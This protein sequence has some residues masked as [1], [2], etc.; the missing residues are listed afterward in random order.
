MMDF[1]LAPHQLRLVNS[2]LSTRIFLA[3][4]AGTG[5]TTA[6][7]ARLIHYLQQGIPAETLLL[8]TPQRTLASPYISAL[9]R[10]RDH[11]GGQV[12][13]LTI[14]G[15]AR[16]MIQLFW[17]IV[18]GNA[19]FRHPDHPPTFLTLETVQ[20]HIA[21]LVRPLLDQGYFSSVTI[22]RNRLYSQ[23][24][25]NL[26]KAAVV[27]FSH[28]EI[29]E[30]LKAAWAGEPG[31]LRVYDDAQYCAI[32]FRDYCIERN[33]LDFSLQIET[34]IKFIWPNELCR[35]YLI[36]TYRHLWVDNVEEDT[37][38]AHEIITEWLPECA[39]A[40]LVYD[41][42]AGYRKFLGASPD[43]G[44]QL[45]QICEEQI[46]FTE[47]FVMSQ[48][49]H[50]LAGILGAKIRKREE[51][52]PRK[53]SIGDNPLRFEVNRFFPSMLDWVCNQTSHL[54]FDMHVPPGEICILSPFLS[55][56][57]RFSLLTRLQKIGIPVKSH[58]P[59][60]ALRDEPATLCV[61]TLALLAHPEWVNGNNELLPNPFD[62]AHAL[63]QAIEGLDLIRAQLLTATLI[64]FAEAN[65]A[66]DIASF[67]QLL[68][69]MKERISYQIG[70]K[71]EYLRSWILYY[72]KSEP[73]EFDYFVSRLFGEVLSQPGFGFH[74]NFHSSEIVANLV[75]S[76]QKFRWVAESSFEGLPKPLGLE[77]VEMVREGIIAAQYLRSWETWLQEE[78]LIAPA[79]TFLMYNKAVDFQFWL[80]VGS[81][82]WSER[83]YQPLTQPYVL[84][85]S[86]DE[87][88]IWTDYD[89]VETSQESLYRLVSGLLH[90]CRHGIFL[91]LSDLG[92]QGYEQRG[93]LLSAFQKTLQ[94][95]YEP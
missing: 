25:D 5:K 66:P 10:I 19:G 12:T 24:I 45:R 59:S 76:I 77:Y 64:R 81:R 32:L 56:A 71:F 91:G 42:D 2:S 31:Q 41:Q 16:R 74:K 69:E 38:V 63:I 1:E 27:G 36:T 62:I 43:T 40:L 9:G 52:I 90:R 22:D 35:K 60:R 21:H 49:V 67:D 53:I 93:P 17:P 94:V 89:E 73:V 82:S 20:Y 61:L 33:F 87:N 8:I 39:S 65:K 78:V 13:S 80:D 70:E 85:R 86:W 75:E 3:G 34:F 51:L 55:D 79:Y 44:L 11:H 48:E 7:V 14:G 47:S 28:L 18:A 83:L 68:P 37:P 88:R 30:K 15:L 84:S 72:R 57:L 92:E 46:T 23:V 4:Q 58:R 29:A 26:N 6:A 95:F 54:I 50:T